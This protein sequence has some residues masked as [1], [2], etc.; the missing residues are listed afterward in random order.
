MVGH[1]LA[2][3]ARVAGHEIEDA[4]RQAGALRKF[5]ERQ[6]GQ[7]RL[8]RGLRHHGAADGER[9][10]DLAGDHGGGEIPWRDRRDHAD[11]LLDHD[12]ARIGAEGRI[13]LAIDALGLLGEELDEAGGVV[14]FAQR[15]RKGLPLLAGHDEGDVVA[16]GDDEV[17]PASQDPR[18]LLGQRLRPRAEGAL[19][20]FDRVNRLRFAKARR[21]GE[22]GAGRRV[23]DRTGPLSNPFAVDQALAFEE[24][25][26]GEFHG[27]CVR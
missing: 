27:V 4:R 6:R 1:R 18:P 13:D 19:S 16:I 12:N 14:D 24:R 11:R 15:L 22:N 3:G 20:G 2:D 7:R 8:A 17:E 21:F 9:R 23:G 10:P 5:A 26:I 25:R